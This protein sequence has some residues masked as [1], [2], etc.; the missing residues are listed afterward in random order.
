MYAFFVKWNDLDVF[1]EDTAQY[2]KAV[3]VSVI[4]R[5]L[6]ESVKVT[7]VFPL[8]DRQRVIAACTADT[9]VGGRN[10]IYLIDGDLG[11]IN[12]PQKLEIKRL[13]THRVYHLENYF[14]CEAALLEI[15]EDE[16]PRLAAEEIRA[17][18]DFGS[19]VN[20]MEPLRDLFS[21]FGVSNTL[22][23]G[24]PTVKIGVDRFT[25]ASK[26]LDPQKIFEFCA[27]RI[28]YL[29]ANHPKRT[30]DAAIKMVNTSIDSKE[31]FLDVIAAREYLFPLL[32][33]WIGSKG[34][35]L[36]AGNESL[37][38]RISKSCELERHTEFKDA[39]RRAATERH[40]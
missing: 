31:F 32:K 29:Y 8:G 23:P 2:A 18:L 9:V 12:D 13:F 30:V 1:V 39:I 27:E 24:L 33:R 7:D 28:A 16:N 38:Y 4:G 19:W 6:P 35:R 3:Y 14:I 37:F 20:D 5:M 21:T 17:R 25:T 22:S 10:R 15:L 11:L 26:N 40:L 36:S 34:L